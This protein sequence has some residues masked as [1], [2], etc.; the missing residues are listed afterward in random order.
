MQ[1]SIET[2]VILKFI[3]WVKSDLNVTYKCRSN[4]LNFFCQYEGYHDVFIIKRL[5]LLMCFYIVKPFFI[6]FF[7]VFF[8]LSMLLSAYGIDIDL[9]Y[10][11]EIMVLKT[12]MVLTHTLGIVLELYQHTAVFLLLSNQPFP[13]PCFWHGGKELFLLSF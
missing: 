10:G 2:F 6:I 12:L 7:I 13:P 11:H 8:Q 3:L 9:Q 5:G 1:K 4:S